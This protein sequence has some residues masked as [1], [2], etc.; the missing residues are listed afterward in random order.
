MAALHRKL[1]EDR[2]ITSLRQT[3]DGK[4]WIRC[5]PFLQYARRV[6][7]L[8]SLRAKM[9]THLQKAHLTFPTKEGK[10]IFP[11]LRTSM[12]WDKACLPP[13]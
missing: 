4:Q 11:S 8:L 2:I 3:R 9:R 12:K 6:G 10:K 5:S 7:P 1:T 13:S